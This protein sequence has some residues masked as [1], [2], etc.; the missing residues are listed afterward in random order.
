[1]GQLGEEIVRNFLQL[2]AVEPKYL[3]T[4]ER[5]E[6]SHLEVRDGA[7]TKITAEAI[8]ID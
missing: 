8:A 4:R 1:M 7:V 3:E 5:V 2:V 6:D